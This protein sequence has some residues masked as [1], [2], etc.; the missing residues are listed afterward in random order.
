MQQCQDQ[1]WGHLFPSSLWT[2]GL[3]VFSPLHIWG[4]RRMRGASWLRTLVPPRGSGSGCS[5]L[6]SS[7]DE[8]LAELAASG[9]SIP[10]YRESFVLLTSCAG[11]R[12]SPRLPWQQ[13]LLK[14]RWECKLILNKMKWRRGWKKLSQSI[15]SH[16]DLSDRFCKKASKVNFASPRLHPPHNKRSSSGPV[17][18]DCHR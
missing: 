5:Y 11:F 15:W 6:C 1:L 8:I 14:Y 18:L 3:S 4:G 13:F 10:F 16:A 7:W 2:L 9:A 12:S 17:S